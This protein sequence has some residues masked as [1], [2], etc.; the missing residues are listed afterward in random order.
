MALWV[1]SPRSV[2]AWGGGGVGQVGPG[3]KGEALAGCVCVWGGNGG[4]QQG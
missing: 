3:T 2:C 4:A 1:A